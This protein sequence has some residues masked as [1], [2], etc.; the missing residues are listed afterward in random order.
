MSRLSTQHF[1]DWTNGRWTQS[2]PDDVAE[3]SIDSR[4][5]DSGQVF[6]AIKTSVRDGH[7]Y[8]KDAKTR[9]A[10]AALVSREVPEVDIP[11]LLVA[12]TGKALRDLALQCRLEFSGTMIAVTGSCGKTSTKELLSILLGEGTLKT[13]GNFNNHLGVPL[14]LLGL[15]KEHTQAVVEIGMNAPG[16]I[17]SLARITQPQYSIITTVAPV[18]LQGV[19]SLEGVAEEKATLAAV[20]Q[21]LTILPVECFRFA[22]FSKL[23]VPCLVMGKPEPGRYY[24]DSCRFVDFSL[25]Q[26]RDQT[27]IVLRPGRGRVLSFSVQRISDGMARNMVLSLL[28]G[29]ELGLDAHELQNRLEAWG[30]SDMR[31]ER[32]RVG[33]LDIFID[34]YNANPTSMRDSLE[35]FRSTTPEDKPR[36]YV[37][38][39]MKELGEYTE[40][41]H[42]ELGRSF[43][44]RSID[45]LFL[46][47]REVPGF[48]SGFR[49]AGRDDEHVSVFDD[50][51]V[52]VTE[53]KGLEGSLFLKGSRAY[54]LEKIYLKLKEIHQP[55]ESPC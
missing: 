50:D 20:T 30:P 14:T 44:L 10:V 27:D 4:I 46:T 22:P 36:Y 34:C 32:D 42:K 23:E 13:R 15:R 24:P 28:L 52:V 53:L 21:K 3:F 40:E 39:G 35:Y 31:C 33:E 26:L 41:Y 2:P 9:G 12:N 38:G 51:R 17:A 55:V 37:I 54:A 8:L 47:G 18:H 11:Q 19:R 16:E 49:A 7:D 43:K 5:V 6:V 1:S 48:L 29:L 25:D 45:R